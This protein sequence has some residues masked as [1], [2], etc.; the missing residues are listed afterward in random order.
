MRVAMIVLMMAAASV[1]HAIPW[2][3]LPSPYTFHDPVPPG[4]YTATV[5][6]WQW[7]ADQHTGSPAFA[8]ALRINGGPQNN[9]LVYDWWFDTDQGYKRV[10]QIADSNNITLNPE[11]G[12]TDVLDAMDGRQ[13]V[14]TV[15]DY[16]TVMFQQCSRV[17]FD[18]YALP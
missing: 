5:L 6:L 12:L 1:A 4:D 3:D 14:V 15:A 13:F 10:K 16:E 9:R 17:T 8:M 7:D 18:G 11:W 2:D